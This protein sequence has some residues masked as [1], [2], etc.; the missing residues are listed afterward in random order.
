MNDSRRLARLDALA[1]LVAQGRSHSAA[2]KRLGWSVRSVQYYAKMPEF[3]GRVRA[4]RESITDRAVGRLV[5]GQV[6][7]A[8]KLSKLVD[9]PAAAPAVQ[10]AAARS[11]LQLPS[12][13][14]AVREL[15]AFLKSLEG[16][17]NAHDLRAKGAG[18][19]SFASNGQVRR[20]GP[21][22]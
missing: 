20:D 10:L 16:R 19:A 7:A 22:G 21:A 2:A 6:K 5:A 8:A 15:E 17:Q 3:D 18:G 13:L 4:I 12:D 1:L 14:G 9:D 11:V